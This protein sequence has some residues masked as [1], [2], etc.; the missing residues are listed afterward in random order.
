MSELSTEQFC[1]IP[2]LK[3]FTQTIDQPQA[4]P[5]VLAGYGVDAFRLAQIA[6]ESPNK[7]EAYGRKV[8][9]KNHEVEVM[10]AKWSYKAMA[11][12][13]NHGSSQGLIWFARGNF[14]EQHYRFQ[15]ANLIQSEAAEFYKE[16]QVV[17]IDS[18]D[19]HSCQPES[20]GMSLHIYC[21]PIHDMK[22]WDAENKRTLIVADECGAWIPENTDLI[23]SEKKW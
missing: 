4:L 21:P 20:T 5:A 18:S 9:F 16:N 12:P 1:E 19:I 23:V 10:L 3:I 8:L 17:T 11:V 6:Q 7:S 13:H 14:L 15:S 2:W 22:V